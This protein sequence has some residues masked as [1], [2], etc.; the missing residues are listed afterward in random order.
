M[1][2]ILQ[3]GGMDVGRLIQWRYNFEQKNSYYSNSYKIRC[4]MN[5]IHEYDWYVHEFHGMKELVLDKNYI[6]KEA[7]ELSN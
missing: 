5:F 7:N 3:P 2:S 4:S 1:S 6:N